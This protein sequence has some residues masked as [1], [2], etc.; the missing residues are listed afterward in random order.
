MIEVIWTHKGSECK[1][2]EFENHFY[3]FVA[4]VFFEP[5]LPMWQ[6]RKSGCDWKTGVRSQSKSILTLLS[7]TADFCETKVL[8]EHQYSITF[9]W[10]LFSNYKKKGFN[11]N[12]PNFYVIIPI[13]FCL[14]KL[15]RLHSTPEHWKEDPFASFPFIKYNSLFFLFTCA[16]SYWIRTKHACILMALQQYCM[17][18]C[19]FEWGLA[20]KPPRKCS[21]SEMILQNPYKEWKKYL[22]IRLIIGFL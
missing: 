18:K 15:N 8:V 9:V 6:K 13:F 21:Y 22:N 4:M 2:D 7:N 12:G 5:K 17:K 1:N 14:I 19:Y 10:K 16:D 20:W 3:M 11:K